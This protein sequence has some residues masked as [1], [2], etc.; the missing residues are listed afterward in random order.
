MKVPF[1]LR[2]V[3]AHPATALL[4]P[5]DAEALLRL[6]STKTPALMGE[7]L[8]KGTLPVIHRVADGFLVRLAVPSEDVFPGAIRLRALSANLFVPVHAELS[9]VLLDDEAK[10]LVHNRGLVFLPGGRVL[11]FAPDAVLSPADLLV[12]PRLPRCTC[13]PFPQPPDRPADLHE[14]ILDIP[15]PLPGQFLDQ[16]GHD[17]GVD[18]IA[19]LD[20]AGGKEKTAQVTALL[21][22]GLFWLGSKLNSKMIARWGASLINEAMQRSRHVRQSILGKQEWALRELLQ[23]FKDGKI[24]DALRRAL[25]LGSSAGRGD[26]V[27]SDANLPSNSL[28]YRLSDFLGGMSG[29]ASVWL[30]GGSVYEE[31]SRAYRTAAIAAAQRGDYVRAAVIYGKLLRDWSSMATMLARASMH[32]DAALVYL[33]LLNDPLQAAREFEAAGE[34]DRALEL[35]RRRGEHLLAG[36]LLRRIG[37]L[38]RAVEEYLKA[39]DLEVSRRNY[40]TAAR[41]LLKHAERLD[42]AEQY[43]VKGWNTRPGVEAVH[44]LQALVDLHGE[45]GDVAK[46]YPLIAQADDYFRPAGEDYH[47][48]H[49]YNHLARLA[50]EKP[51]AVVRE[52]LL[53]RALLGLARKLEGRAHE[54]DR[55]GGILSLLFNPSGPWEPALIRDAEVA[56]RGLPRSKS[57]RRAGR[58]FRPHSWAEV[59][60]ACAARRTGD[61]FLGFEDGAL[62]H[63]RPRTGEL[64]IVHPN[65]H[66]IVALAC[67]DCGQ[68]V[69][70]VRQQEKDSYELSSHLFG[71]GSGGLQARHVRRAE[72]APRLTPV[73]GV[74]HAMVVGFWDGHF[75]EYLSYPGLAVEAV[76]PVPPYYQTALLLDDR[77]IKAAQAAT[78]LFDYDSLTFSNLQEPDNRGTLKLSLPW[79]LGAPACP[80]YPWLSWLLAAQALLEIVNINKEAV[81]CW[82]SFELFTPEA[83]VLASCRSR[84]SFPM[85]AGAIVR[86]GLIAG[87]HRAGVGWYRP[88]QSLVSQGQTRIDLDEPVVCFPSHWTNELL[89]VCQK[90][91]VVSV[92]LPG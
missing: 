32:H 19:P 81:L 17:I 50:Q 49:F 87:V 20:T 84:E 82:G 85:L 68:F 60:A 47:A 8:S 15:D 16:A 79:K 33:Q 22:K 24:D 66:L 62:V 61:L 92:P 37:E 71:E 5:D 55:G 40:T 23:K 28:L 54:G 18:P 42:L 44:C 52:D 13:R 9:P 78:V 59:T 77:T 83:K 2:Q 86:S 74:H 69:V 35:Y 6:C 4:L 65:S 27:A 29:A 91:E 51:F 58:R 34:V 3:A 41:L 75:L 46:L 30:G 43:L 73:A 57:P 89:I 45:R 48:A 31:L 64:T 56:L 67:D 14:I 26:R 76:L 1:Q 63:Y 53:D 38:D 70:E 36:D 39:A 25:P 80:G 72:V 7:A 90:G 88:G 10:A 11:A 21:G 12:V